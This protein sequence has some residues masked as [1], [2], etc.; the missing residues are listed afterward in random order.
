MSLAVFSFGLYQTA[1][2]A[3]IAATGFTGAGH[4]EQVHAG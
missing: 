1:T 4:A 2:T 3:A